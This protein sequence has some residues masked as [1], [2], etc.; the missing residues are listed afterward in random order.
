MII[1]IFYRILST[2]I[3]QSMP[4]PILSFE[5]SYGLSKK[6]NYYIYSDLCFNSIG[7]RRTLKNY[8]HEKCEMNIISY[9]F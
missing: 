3:N 8:Q 4:P 2:I 1:E 6:E 5:S 7:L 9:S